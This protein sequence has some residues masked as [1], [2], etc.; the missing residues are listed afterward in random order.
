MFL[1]T[2]EHIQMFFAH[3][4]SDQNVLLGILTRGL[5]VFEIVAV[6]NMAARCHQACYDFPLN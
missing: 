4:R 2:E 6:A 3:G 5:M 1:D